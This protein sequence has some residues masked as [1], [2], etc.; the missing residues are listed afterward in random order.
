ML[1]RSVTQQLLFSTVRL[2]TT[3]D[4][5]EM[6]ATAF[7]FHYPN[8]LDGDQVFPFL[9]TNKH[10]L[11]GAKSCTFFL[12]RSKGDE[13]DI[14]NRTDVGIRGVDLSWHG[15]P[16]DGVDVAVTP[17]GP[18]LNT[19]AE[20][21]ENV[22]Y[23]PVGTGLI[24]TAEALR[25]ID[26]VEDVLFIGYPSGLYDEVNLIPV[27]RKG[28]LATPVQLD[29]NGL[30]AFL[31]DASVFPG[32]SGS[33]VFLYNPLGY[34]PPGKGWQLGKGR[35]LLLGVVAEVVVRMDEGEIRLVESPTAVRPII[36]SQQMIDLGIVFKS[37]AI[38]E[39]IEGFLAKH[40]VNVLPP[41]EEPDSRTD[42]SQP[43]TSVGRRQL[44]SDLLA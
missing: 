16:V 20:R 10:V 40:G 41:T 11:S 24:P 28:T 23:R 17:L 19:I 27:S 9:V 44:E 5:G 6:C 13:P 2:V 15:H 36:R 26:A 3:S 33:P 31:I 21:G 8:P 38:V 43:Q 35:I 39:T 37:S 29:Y 12:T 1:V 34:Q 30:P 7:I 22:F 25:E 32:S 14:G 42:E 18:L 4:E